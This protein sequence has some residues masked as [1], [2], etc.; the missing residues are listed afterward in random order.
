VTYSSS[1]QSSA[2]T[3]TFSV[4]LPKPL[5][6]RLLGNRDI[7]AFLNSALA[8]TSLP[9][10]PAVS[11][12][13]LQV[14]TALAEGNELASS[15]AMVDL[16]AESGSTLDE[17]EGAAGRLK[18]LNQRT[19][20]ELMR[21]LLLCR[22]LLHDHIEDGIS[23]SRLAEEACMSEFHLMRCFRQSFGM[24]VAQYLLR[25]R[26]QRAARLL[27]AG[28]VP[29]RLVAAQ[30]GYADLSAFGRAFRRHWGRSATERQTK[31]AD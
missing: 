25:L 22:T 27:D 2:P 9:G 18:A 19:K 5:V 17:I 16:V 26:M 3:D 13:L 4:F 20:A 28:D 14:A 21:R 12:G 1:I 10:L 23:L 6:E 8:C 30:C 31:P 15:E 7:D 24:S 29:V 11:R